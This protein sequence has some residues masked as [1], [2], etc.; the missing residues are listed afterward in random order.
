MIRPAMILTVLALLPCVPAARAQD[1]MG[2]MRQKMEEISRLMR[3]SEELLLQLT[4]VDRLIA[5]QQELIRKLKELEPP[6][7]TASA[8]EAREKKRSE[9]RN[10]QREIEQN[11]QQMLENQEQ[12][13]ELTVEE[14]QKLL[15]ALPRQQGMGQGN[16]KHRQQKKRQK[17]EERRL[18]E[19]QQEQKQKDSKSPRN[20]KDL[21]KDRERKDGTQ[22]PRS[23]TGSP[24]RRMIQAWIAS[25][26]PADA[27]RLLRGDFSKVPARYRRL[28]REY[29]IL[30]ARRE[31]EGAEEGA[32]R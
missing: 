20:K 23:E 16:Q 13:C 14:L 27:E 9:L 21:F 12:I 30:R 8:E 29:T 32:G 7:E 6:L 28:V 11:L 3:E 22:R 19:K 24:G 17:D 10:K 5:G 4:K 15:E 18:R 1:Q 2:K 31:A 25:L 26:P